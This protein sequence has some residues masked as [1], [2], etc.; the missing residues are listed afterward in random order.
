DRMFLLPSGA[1]AG[2]FADVLA[3]IASAPPPRAPALPKT[4]T[5]GRMAARA[6]LLYRGV[7]VGAARHRSAR[8][9]VWLLTNNFSTGGAQSSARRLLIGLNARGHT[10][11]AATIEE[12]PERLSPGRRALSAAGIPVT[13]I[14]PN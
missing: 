4:F 14:P 9:V 13:A 7:L 8:P 2:A 10:V 5:R 11:R 12:A 1:D 6:Q 3:R